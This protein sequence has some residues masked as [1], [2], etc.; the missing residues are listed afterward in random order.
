M[1]SVAGNTLPSLRVRPFSRLLCPSNPQEI[2]MNASE[3]RRNFL[4]GST[5]FAAA[6]LATLSNPIA[7]AAQ[8]VKVKRGDLPDLP[9]KEEKVYVTE[10]S[11]LHK[12][13]SSE[14]GD[15]ISVVT[16]SGI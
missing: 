11:K 12:L 1:Q 10:I 4:A 7:A 16:N 6:G 5:G 2:T 13:N 14:T 15:L 3:S 9:I 8:S